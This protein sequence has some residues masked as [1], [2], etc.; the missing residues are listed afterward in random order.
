M[1]E[2]DNKRIVVYA[3]DYYYGVSHIIKHTLGKHLN[4][5]RKNIRLYQKQC[6]YSTEKNIYFNLIYI[7]CRLI[8]KILDHLHLSLTY[9]NILLHYL[10]S[11]YLSHLLVMLFTKFYGN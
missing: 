5:C 11:N 7:L 8:I 6:F 1:F 2:W 10:N 3:L 4:K 9:T